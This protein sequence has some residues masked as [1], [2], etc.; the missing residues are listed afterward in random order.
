M[1][2]VVFKANFRDFKANLKSRRIF[3]C[4]TCNLGFFPKQN[5]FTSYCSRSCAFMAKARPPVFSEIQIGYC[6]ECGRCVVKKRNKN[7]KHFLCSLTCSKG[8]W[9]QVAKKHFVSVRNVNPQTEKICAYCRRGFTANV[10]VE[11]IKY[12]SMGCAK[13]AFKL[14]RK[15]RKKGAFREAVYVAE[16]VKRD[17]GI[18][19][20]CNK[21][22]ALKKC[23]PHPN[24]PTL[25]HIVPLSKGGTHE[26]INVQ[27]AHFRCNSLRGNHGPAQPRLIA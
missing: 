23:A 8:F 4:K 6:E 19:Q 18:C 12:C 22:V 7:R 1:P 3:K 9:A 25:D 10:R 16:I 17:R 5:T 21:R 26:P 13:R 20:L 11:R 2:Q 15:V 24:S 27:L 14:N